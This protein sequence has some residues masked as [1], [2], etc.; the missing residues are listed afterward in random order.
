MLSISP[1]YGFSFVSG[2]VNGLVIV[3]TGVG[4]L[5]KNTSKKN[6]DSKKRQ[7]GHKGGILY[8]MVTPTEFNSTAARA[9]N[10]LEGP[11]GQ[12]LLNLEE[13]ILEQML[14]QVFGFQSLQIGSW[15]ESD[16]FV[17]HSKTLRHSVLCAHAGEGVDIVG[18]ADELPI[19]SDSIDA[20]LLPH[21]LEHHGDPHQVLREVQ[22]VLVCEGRVIITGFSPAS[23]WGLRHMVRPRTRS[24][25]QPLTER[26]V[27]DWLRLLGLEPVSSNRYFYTPPIEHEVVLDR[28]AGL[29]GV[30]RKWWPFLNGAYAITAKKS[31]VRAA[32]VGRSWHR[33]RRVVG[34][35]AEPATRTADVIGRKGK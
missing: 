8:S 32:M 21:T 11:V 7:G 2:S 26:R 15:G 27:T 3:R 17:Q 35:L 30:G 14:E 18:R 24:I 5:R 31:M 6:Y 23:I 16:R 13:Q 9:A 29:E 28:T 12:R 10:W 4:I 19:A 25:A 22:R 34:G 20:V 1:N 33:K